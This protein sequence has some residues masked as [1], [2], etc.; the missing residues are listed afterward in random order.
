MDLWDDVDA[1]LEE[2]ESIGLSFG[3]EYSSTI[4]WVCDFTPRSNH[5]Q[6]RQY[7]IWHGQSEVRETAI[8]QALDRARA[9]L[10]ATRE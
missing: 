7:G 6:A 1:L 2:H 10:G 8:R 9:A 3:M 5:P 4:G